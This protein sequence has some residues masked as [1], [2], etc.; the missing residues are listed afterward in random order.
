MSVT[1]DE[2]R[3]WLPISDSIYISDVVEKG[4]VKEHSYT[5]EAEWR[6]IHQEKTHNQKVPEL[7]EENFPYMNRIFCKY[8]GSR[9]RR[10]INKDGSITWICNGL[11]S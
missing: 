8:C 4:V 2:V 11:S 5:P 3:S 9:L 1:D 6:L 7:T 10:I